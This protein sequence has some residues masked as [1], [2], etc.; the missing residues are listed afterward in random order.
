MAFDVDGGF[1][2]IDLGDNLA[3]GDPIPFVFFPLHEGALG[4]IGAEC[5]HDKISH[6]PPEA[7]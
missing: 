2:R 7:S 6:E 5:R 3:L 1:L 4:H